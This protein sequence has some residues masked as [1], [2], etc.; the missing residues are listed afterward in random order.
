MSFKTRLF[1]SVSHGKFFM[2]LNVVIR[3]MSWAAQFLIQWNGKH[4]TT[5][6]FVRIVTGHLKNKQDSRRAWETSLLTSQTFI[7]ILS[8]QLLGLFL[9]PEGFNWQKT[10]PH[11]NRLAD[12]WKIVSL[13]VPFLHTMPWM[14]N[15]KDTWYQMHVGHS[16]G[17]CCTR[18]CRCR[19]WRH[20]FVI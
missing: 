19:Y 16:W 17:L 6:T 20:S 1:H 13:H 11:R 2:C 7:L 4:S 10:C 8:V 18:L 9:L 15:D 14:C 5:S 3:R 12:V